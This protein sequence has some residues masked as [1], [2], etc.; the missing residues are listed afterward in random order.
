MGK[1]ESNS[2]LNIEIK[3]YPEG[4]NHTMIIIILQGTLVLL[5]RDEMRGEHERFMKR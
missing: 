3:N 5:T 1:T 4:I 2:D